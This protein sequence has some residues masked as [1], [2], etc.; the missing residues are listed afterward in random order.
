MPVR[1]SK[2]SKE[3]VK[4]AYVKLK[5]HIYYDTTELF[6]RRK[7]AEYVESVNISVWANKRLIFEK[8]SFV[9]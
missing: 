2:I 8:V 6:Q 4:A 9:G 1:M 3:E 7:L 5:S